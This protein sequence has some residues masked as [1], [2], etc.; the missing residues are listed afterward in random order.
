VPQTHGL[1]LQGFDDPT[2]AAFAQALASAGDADA[3]VDAPDE[4]GD[5]TT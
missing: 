1:S 2:T 4:F 3:E 5:N